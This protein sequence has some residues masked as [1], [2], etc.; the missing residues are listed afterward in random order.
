VRI[1]VE[2]LGVL[3]KAEFDVGDLTIICG[4][5]NTGKTYAT[6]ALYGFMNFWNEAYS[7]N[8]LGNATI[9]K[10]FSNG[11]IKVELDDIRNNANSILDNACQVYCHKLPMVFAASEKIFT[12]TVFHVSLSND[13]V[14]FVSTAKNEQVLGPNRRPVFCLDKK[15]GEN[16]VTIN[17][18]AKAEEI[19]ENNEWIIYRINHSLL[20]TL[21]GNVIPSPFVASIE[22]TGAAIFR[23]ELDISRNRL[24]E[25]VSN[26]DK[27]IDP[28]AL[29]DTYFDKGYAL[30]VKNDVDFIRNLEDVVKHDSAISKS[31]PDIQESFDKI[32]G[33]EYRATKE[34]LYYMPHK[35]HARLTM[36][37]S[38]S[39]IRSLL[40]LG[41]YIKHLACPGGMLMID[42]PELNLHPMNQRRM[43]RILAKL[44][45][46]GIKVFITTHSDYILK[47][48]NTLI[49]LGSLNSDADRIMEK[50]HYHK[51]ELL[52]VGRVK[53][54]IAKKDLLSIDGV[55]KRQRHNT[56]VPAPID[57]YGIEISDFDETI[58]VMNSIQDELLFGGSV[59]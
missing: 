7:P 22:R 8:L 44:V 28:I 53:A 48:L 47:E 26:R 54:Y 49:M 39:S 21:F 1:T 18:L 31:N 23:K 42:E 19:D 37:A 55:A 4:A 9:E 33:G 6:Y 50:Y 25:H 5:N 13:D 17:L 57:E 27:D 20:E 16:F 45:N 51:N 11:S 32:L 24:L 46:A 15:H 14:D 56:F 3:K 43:A 52:N 36:G 40:N 35:S 2:N 10:L 58:N 12:D 41:I 34:G 38:S 29:I 59:E 30:P